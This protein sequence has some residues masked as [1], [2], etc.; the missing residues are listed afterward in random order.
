[1]DGFLFHARRPF[2]STRLWRLFQ[3]P[4]PEAV[5]I[6]GVFWTLNPHDF[7]GEWSCVGGAVTVRSAGPWL[8]SLP[9][10]RWPPADPLRERFLERVWREPWG[11]RRQD[12]VFLGPGLDEERVRAQLEATLLDDATWDAQR[13]T[14]RSR[15]A[16]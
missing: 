6:S 1:M 11:D 5:T 4:W 7:A 12:L 15:S 16:A 13:E 9:P 3:A 14:L 2:A 8:A 10:D